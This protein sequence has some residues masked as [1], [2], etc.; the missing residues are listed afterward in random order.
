M[1]KMIT[2]AMETRVAGASAWR[3]SQKMGLTKRDVSSKTYAESTGGAL[4]AGF[5]AINTSPN[6]NLNQ[7]R[8]Q[9]RI[10]RPIVQDG[11]KSAEH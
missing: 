3:R 8:T 2:V 11:Q 1:D 9:I 7:T 5:L 10:P 6:L 4:I